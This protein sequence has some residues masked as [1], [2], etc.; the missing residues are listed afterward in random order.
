MKKQGPS[1]RP[2]VSFKFYTASS[3]RIRIRIKLKGRIQIPIRIKVISWIRIRI[4]INLQMTSQN[5]WNISL[6]ELFLKVLSF[7][8]EARNRSK[9]KVGSGSA[10]KWKAGS[11]SET[12]LPPIH[13][14]GW[15]NSWLGT[16]SWI[17]PAIQ[18]LCTWLLHNQK[19]RTYVS[20]QQQARIKTQ[21]RSS[22][23]PQSGQSNNL[24]SGS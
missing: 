4:R 3:Q 17:S 5:V 2:K 22:I 13:R 15:T 18:A 23:L 19:S 9:W 11:G 24:G 8:L 1:I 12:L 20:K 14:S 6:F 10:S 7:Y 16:L 21:N